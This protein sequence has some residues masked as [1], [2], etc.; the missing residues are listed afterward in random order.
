MK[1]MQAS[2][3]LFH[4]TSRRF[5]AGQWLVLPVICLIIWGMNTAAA[6]TTPFDLQGHRGARGLL[7][8]N[9]L[10]AFEKAMELGVSTLELDV[11]VTKDGIVVISHDRALNPEITRDASGAYLTAPVLV[12]RLTLAEIKTYDVGRIN[13][14][15]A[16]AKRFPTQQPVDGTR[17]PALSTLFKRMEALGAKKLRFNIETKISP[18]KPNDTVS[19]AVFARKLLDVVRKHGMTSRVTIQ[20]FDWRTLQIVQELQKGRTKKVLTSCLSSQQPWG[21]NITP[22]SDKG[23]YWTGSVRTAEYADVPSMVKAAGCDVWSPYFA[24]ITPALVKKSHELGLK[25]IPWT[26]N[27]EAEMTAVIDAGAD[28]LITDYPDRARVVLKNRGIAL[29]ESVK[30]TP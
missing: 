5:H 2:H 3:S 9:T 17:M 30:I 4:S 19:A 20:S 28:G 13:P 24:D 22:K 27:S 26:T 15:S 25:V 10:P 7:P 11:G 6:Q 12:N 18:E 21:D 23:L 16:Y 8:E 1:S 14:E 29:P